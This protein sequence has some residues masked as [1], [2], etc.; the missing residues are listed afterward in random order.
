MEAYNAIKRPVPGV[1]DVRKGKGGF[2]LIPT[3]FLRRLA[4]H[5]ENGAE[6]HGDHNWERGQY[7]SG[8]IDSAMRH[9]VSL[10]EGQKDEDHA[11][12]F[13]F[14]A[15]GIATGKLPAAL[16]DIHYCDQDE[17]P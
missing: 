11:A 9:L 15:H 16:D 14:T 17:S 4:R 10:M 6:K 1:R 8:F 7:L 13:M 2:D 12:A 3:L 5:F